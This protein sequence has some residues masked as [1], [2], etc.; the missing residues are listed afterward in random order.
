MTFKLGSTVR[1]DVQWYSEARKPGHK[2]SRSN[3][4]GGDGMYRVGFNPICAAVNEGNEVPE[5]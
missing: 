4:F 3:Y 5:W 2:K 1:R